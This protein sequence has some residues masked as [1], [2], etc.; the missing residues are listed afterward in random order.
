MQ[1]CGHALSGVSMVHLLLSWLHWLGMLG[2]PHVVPAPACAS[3]P[4]DAPALAAL[5]RHA[6]S[7]TDGYAVALRSE[8]VHGTAALAVTTAAPDRLAV[9]TVSQR[10]DTLIDLR[11]QDGWQRWLHRDELRV[12][13]GERPGVD[14]VQALRRVSPYGMVTAASLRFEGPQPNWSLKVETG[15][16]R[17]VWQ[18]EAAQGRVLI[19]SSGGN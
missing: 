1:H 2:H 14:L 7:A 5:V 9:A 3:P 13:H 15:G 10:D 19:A 4:A 18:V 8:C 17:Q 6:E 11:W 12:T 16:S